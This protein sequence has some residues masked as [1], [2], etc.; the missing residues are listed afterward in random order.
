MDATLEDAGKKFVDAVRRMDSMVLRCLALTGRDG[1]RNAYY[2]HDAYTF[3][4]GSKEEQDLILN[5]PLDAAFY[6]T[7]L[8]LYLDSRL[9]DTTDAVNSELTFRPVDWTA[10]ND[11]VFPSNV[12]AK[13]ANCTFSIR[14]SAGPYSSSPMSIAHC[15]S[16][17]Q[18]VPNDLPVSA[19]LGGLDFHRPYVIERGEAMMVRV[20]PIYTKAVE[21]YDPTSVPEYRVTAVLQGFKTVRAFR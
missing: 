3:V 21:V 17:R 18:G 20:A 9:V 6:G 4:T 7:R 8:D 10:T 13:Q 5:N 12:A 14:T 15:F 11:V 2:I 1:D 19:Y 16:A